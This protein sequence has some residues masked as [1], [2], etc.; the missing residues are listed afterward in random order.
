M[1][2]NDVIDENGKIVAIKNSKILQELKVA[3]VSGRPFAEYDVLYKYY[4]DKTSL[5]SL[6]EWSQLLNAINWSDII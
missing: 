1:D 6:S 5:M 4:A 3:H 2:V